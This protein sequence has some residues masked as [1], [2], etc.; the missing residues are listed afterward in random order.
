MT[1]K[2]LPILVCALM[3]A[4]LPTLAMARLLRQPMVEHHQQQRR[5]RQPAL[6]RSATSKMSI[7]TTATSTSDYPWS[8]SV[9]A[10]PPV[11]R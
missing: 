3:L 4:L 5:D 10:A 9:D 1:F 6:T 7:S 8:E 11:T 2:Q